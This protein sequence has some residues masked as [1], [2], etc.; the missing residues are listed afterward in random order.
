MPEQIGTVEKVKN[1]GCA[2]AITHK[3]TCIW[4]YARSHAPRFQSAEP[5]IEEVINYVRVR[6]T[7]S[8]TN[9]IGS[10]ASGYPHENRPNSI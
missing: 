7:A 6:S 2:A 4:A 10:G 5:S 1:G 3:L 9:A 8:R